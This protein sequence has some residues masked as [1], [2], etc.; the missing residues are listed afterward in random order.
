MSFF[1]NNTR[2]MQSWK[3]L[4]INP[5][6]QFL[7]A[8]DTRVSLREKPDDFHDFVVCHVMGGFF[9]QKGYNMTVTE[10]E[11]DPLFWDTSPVVH[12]GFR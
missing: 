7:H 9:Q 4:F 6:S 1:I 10:K 5:D 12:D 8:R 11:F 2:Y 3:I